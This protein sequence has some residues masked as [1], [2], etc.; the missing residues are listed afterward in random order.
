MSEQLTVRQE[1]MVLDAILSAR[2]GAVAGRDL[3]VATLNLNPDLA[4]QGP[5][6]PVGTVI[7]LP[8]APQRETVPR[9]VVSLF[10]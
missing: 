5:V 9:R 7:S 8:P 1:G 2:F 10:G 4:A 3:V 6:L